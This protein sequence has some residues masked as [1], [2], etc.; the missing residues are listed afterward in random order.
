MK[1]QANCEWRLDEERGERRAEI[2]RGNKRTEKPNPTRK[3]AN[4]ERKSD[5]ETGERRREIE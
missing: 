5:E 2:G 3:Q 4:G 1:E